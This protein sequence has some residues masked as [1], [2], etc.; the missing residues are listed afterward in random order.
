MI[1]SAQSEVQLWWGTCEPRCEFLYSEDVADARVH[2]MTLPEDIFAQAFLTE[3]STPIVNVGWGKDKKIKELAAL[4]AEIV[5]FL[6][7]LV[8]NPNMPDG[9]P[10]KLLDT[11]QTENLM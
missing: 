8:F 4:I 3:K 5:D 11:T 1:E 10:V 2:V 6:G 9:T 7:K